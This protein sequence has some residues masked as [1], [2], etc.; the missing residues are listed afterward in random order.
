MAEAA[1]PPATDDQA[2]VPASAG[3]TVKI[4]LKLRVDNR[5]LVVFLIIQA[6]PIKKHIIMI[7]LGLKS[8]LKLNKQM[9]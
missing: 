1:M 5:L 8:E 2:A 3:D 7:T 4:I 9:E 6:L